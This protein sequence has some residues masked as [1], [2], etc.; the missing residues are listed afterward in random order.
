MVEQIGRLVGAPIGQGAG[1]A[2]AGLG[3][4]AASMVGRGLAG[5]EGKRMETVGRGLGQI[6]KQLPGAGVFGDMAGAMKKGGVMGAG[7]AGV[8]GIMGF[9]KQILQSSK[10]FQGIAGSFFKIFG[11]MADV[12]LIP[13][14]PLAMKGMN[15]L[16]KYLPMMSK[17]GQEMANRLE[18]FFKAVQGNK[19]GAFFKQFVMVPIFEALNKL[20][21]KGTK[22]G[23]SG[24]GLYL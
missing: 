19:L 10:V 1:A 9:V 12:F 22:G 8:A 18:E 15:E 16:M 3:G 13:F 21:S 23:H 6:A 17:K 2:G 24:K 7:M 11:A 5:P 4:R 20:V 14:L